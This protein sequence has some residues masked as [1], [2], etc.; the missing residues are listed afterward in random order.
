MDVSLLVTTVVPTLV[1]WLTK[2]GDTAAQK[3]GESIWGFLISKSKNS[4]REKQ[5]S[6]LLPLLKN[7]PSSPELQAALKQILI[8][9]LKQDPAFAKELLHFMQP[10]IHYDQRVGQM[11]DSNNTENSYN[12]NQYNSHN[13]SGSNNQHNSH[14]QFLLIMINT[15]LII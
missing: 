7:Y 12:N 8:E 3:A 2:A 10:Y 5:Y 14:N 15:L 9:D 1:S 13:Q 4:S 11:Y 6:G